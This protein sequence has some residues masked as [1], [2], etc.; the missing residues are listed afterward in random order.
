MNAT[1]SHRPARRPRLAW[2]GLVVVAVLA[3]LLLAGPATPRA[4]AAPVVGESVF[5]GDAVSARAALGRVPVFLERYASAVVDELPVSERRRPLTNLY[6]HLRTFD[7][8]V[9]VMSRYRLEDRGL[10]RRRRAIVRAG[11][12]LSASLSNFLNAVHVAD[13]DEIQ[14]LAPI[15]TRQIDAFDGSIL[16]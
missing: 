16:P 12:P 2:T 5:L 3:S 9:Y 1:A 13:L 4:A 10:D 8:R 15:V 6:R 14:R 11:L 7:Q